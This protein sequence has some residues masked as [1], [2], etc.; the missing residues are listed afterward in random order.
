ME[1]AGAYASE[2]SPTQS[3][4]ALTPGQFKG[5]DIFALSSLTYA[6]R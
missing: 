5:N 1:D 6:T 3:G 4:A 2:R